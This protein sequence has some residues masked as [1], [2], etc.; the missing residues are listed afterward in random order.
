MAGLYVMGGV[1]GGFSLASLRA[2]PGWFVGVA[3]GCLLVGWGA[4]F[5]ELR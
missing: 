2:E 4:Y 5:Q 3:V 1:V